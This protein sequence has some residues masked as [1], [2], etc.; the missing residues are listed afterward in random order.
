MDQDPFWG[1]GFW[2]DI[3]ARALTLV[4]GIQQLVQQCHNLGGLFSGNGN[5]QSSN[6]STSVVHRP[7]LSKPGE[8]HSSLANEGIGWLEKMVLNYWSAI[9]AA[10]TEASQK[11]SIPWPP[12]R[13]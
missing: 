1:P 8:G 10:T 9:M 3:E 7:H 13:S 2:E 5:L 11:K 6:P 12:I 4:K